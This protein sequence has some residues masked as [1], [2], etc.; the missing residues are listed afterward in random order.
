MNRKFTKNCFAFLIV[1]GLFFGLFFSSSATIQA[2]SAEPYDVGEYTEDEL[3]GMLLYESRYFT[4][5]TSVSDRILATLQRDYPTDYQYWADTIAYFREISNNLGDHL[6]V[7]GTAT[8]AWSAGTNTFTPY[9]LDQIDDSINTGT[10]HA[11]IVLGN[12][13]SATNNGLSDIGLRRVQAAVVLAEKFPDSLFVLTGGYTN[14]AYPTWS[15]ANVMATY[16][17][18]QGVDSGRLLLEDQATNTVTNFTNS[19]ATLYA[20]GITNITVLSSPSHVRRA[21]MIFYAA[22]YSYGK[23]NNVP[24]DIVLN[25]YVSYYYANENEMITSSN[26]S[27]WSSIVVAD[28]TITS[29][30]WSN[31]WNSM[32]QAFPSNIRNAYSALAGSSG[33]GPGGGGGSSA[34]GSTSVTLKNEGTTVATLKYHADNTAPLPLAADIGVSK[35]GYY[36]TGWAISPNTA[37][38]YEDGAVVV[39]STNITLE[40]VYVIDYPLLNTIPSY[41]GSETIAPELGGAYSDFVRLEYNGQTVDPA[42]YEVSSGSTIIT[43]KKAYLDTFANGSYTFKVIFTDGISYFTIV[44]ARPAAVAAAAVPTAV[45][46]RIPYLTGLAALAGLYLTFKA[47]KK[48]D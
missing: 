35:P 40:A 30:G 45:V 7:V 34:L 44:I 9:P 6:D 28:A 2:A 5:D 43:L 20:N 37:V 16:M 23:A 39:G 42:N 4:N 17:I 31:C 11:F 8:G 22:M 18:S 38:D 48:N 10:K 19:M 33:G 3:I 24:Y 12:A 41:T 14:N 26:Q 27:D 25:G 36:F 29:E 46:D 13:I 21:G 47:V 32:M 1:F 15:E